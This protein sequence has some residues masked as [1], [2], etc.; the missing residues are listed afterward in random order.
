MTHAPAF[1]MFS[2]MIQ[3]QASYLRSDLEMLKI[4]K[5]QASNS[6]KL[7]YFSHLKNCFRNGKSFFRIFFQITFF[8][9]F[10]FI[11][12]EKF[13]LLSTQSY[14]RINADLNLL[15]ICLNESF[16][17]TKER[18]MKNKRRQ[19]E[20]LKLP[21]N[22]TLFFSSKFSFSLHLESLHL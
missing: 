13:L 2:L 5:R 4:I 22:E 20:K 19:G 14:K 18:E 9:I 12:G 15:F 10:I 1:E 17:E 6:F 8:F 16:E 3:H 7:N 11:L 21:R